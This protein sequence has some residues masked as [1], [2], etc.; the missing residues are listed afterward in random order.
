[1]CVVCCVLCVIHR[2]L[3]L[4]CVDVGCL[5]FYGV[6]RLLLSGVR[7]LFVDVCCVCCLLL[8]YVS[9]LLILACFVG[10]SCCSLCVVVVC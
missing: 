2:G 5:L 6:R 10:R 1:M 7:G 8:M 4:L 9:W 3:P